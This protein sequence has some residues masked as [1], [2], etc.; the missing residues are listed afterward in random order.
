M[1]DQ[2]QGPD[3]LADDDSTDLSVEKLI[4]RYQVVPYENNLLGIRFLNIFEE[5]DEFVISLNDAVNLRESLRVGIEVVQNER[6]QQQG[7]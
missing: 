5:G 1:D 4:T 2:N 6:G 7:P 3:G